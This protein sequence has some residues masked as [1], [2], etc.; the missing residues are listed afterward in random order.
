MR[1]QDRCQAGERLAR[2]LAFLARRKPVVMALARGGVPVAVEVARALNAPIDLL[3][4]RKIGAPDN[5]ELAVGAVAEEGAS[6][7]D[8][9]CAATLGMSA[10]QLDEKAARETQKLR[11]M[12]G[13]L[14]AG[15]PQVDVRGR[16][17]I[18]VDDGMATGMTN[19]AAVRALRKRGAASV[20]VAVPV[21]S[22]EAVAMVDREADRVVALTVPQRLYGVG[23]WYEDFRPVDD[24]RVLALLADAR[25][26]VAAL[27]RTPPRG[28]QHDI[29]FAVDGHSLPAILLVPDCARGLVVFAHGSGS[30]RLSPRNRAVAEGLAHAGLASLLFDLLVEVEQSRRELV[31]DVPLLAAR[32]EQVTVQARARPGMGALPLGFFGASTGAA[33]ALSAAASLGEPVAAVVS[34][35]GRPDL[36]GGRLADVL[37][38]TLL[39]VGERDADVLEL[40][41]R[42]A[43]QMRCPHELALVAGAGHLFEEPGALERVCQ[44][45]VDWFQRHL[46]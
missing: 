40:N 12:A 8:P 30:S 23:M 31:F 4:V 25:R 16:I 15:R 18:A 33:A 42:A 36:A 45:A 6:A 20:V 5:P 37:C 17:A 35:G 2:E 28:G 22:P 26:H 19:L 3:A 38:P 41:R 24:E 27:T 29:T 43:A 34:R 13:A 46:R 14:R 7:L 9:D 32:L 39:V 11:R 44:L 1:Y 21:A 10:E